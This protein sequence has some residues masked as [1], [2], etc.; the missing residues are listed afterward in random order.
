MESDP[1][2]SDAIYVDLEKYLSKTKGTGVELFEYEAHTLYA[3][4][5]EWCP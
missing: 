1:I 4:I 2:D 3:M 5:R